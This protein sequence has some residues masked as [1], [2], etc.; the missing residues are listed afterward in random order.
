MI[1]V[2][3]VGA[4]VIIGVC[5]AAGAAP[6]VPAILS[7]IWVLVVA[8]WMPRWKIFRR[9]DDEPPPSTFRQD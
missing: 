1:P 3:I 2:L 5:K 4:V 6:L 7:G 9:P 8:Y